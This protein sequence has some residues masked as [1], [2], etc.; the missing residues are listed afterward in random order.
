MSIL[1]FLIIGTQSVVNPQLTTHNS[2]LF[3]ISGNEIADTAIKAVNSQLSAHNSEASLSQLFTITPI[4][5]PASIRLPNGNYKF[6]TEISNPSHIAKGNG[7]T[8]VWVKI[9]AESLKS[10][11]ENRTPRT[12]HREPNTEN[13]P[14]KSVPVAL[15]VRFLAPMVVAKTKIKKHTT[16]TSH[17]VHIKLCDA[18]LN[19]KPSTLQYVLGKR[20]KKVFAKGQI[21]TS[22]KIESL[23]LVLA[24]KQVKVIYNHNNVTISTSGVSHTDG[25]MDD[26][27][28]VQVFSKVVDAKV[29]GINC[30]TII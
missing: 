4:R 5:I 13:Q 25:W 30:V 15:K 10:T 28:K 6:E 27:L 22:D 17:N 26:L 7:A 14:I 20:T 1:L 11:T 8:L 19:P 23:P 2:R 29:I 16:L 24:Q 9:F 18:T 12:E 21:V 3:T